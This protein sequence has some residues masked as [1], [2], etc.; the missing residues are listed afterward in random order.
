[1]NGEI[2]RRYSY[3]LFKNGLPVAL[4]SLSPLRRTSSKGQSE[5]LPHLVCGRL[6]SNLFESFRYPF[7]FQVISK[8]SYNLAILL[9]LTLNH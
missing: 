4:A 1:M 7:A 8:Q 2:K 6:D 9:Q 3:L 5:N